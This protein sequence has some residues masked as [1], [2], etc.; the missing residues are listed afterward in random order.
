M[1]Q[2]S[3]TL[4]VVLCSLLLAPA[5]SPRAEPEPAATTRA[6]PAAAASAD[7]PADEPA[8]GEAATDTGAGE[9]DVIEI[10]TEDDDRPFNL[11]AG[12]PVAPTPASV[13]WREVTSD[14][15]AIVFEYVAGGVLA[16]I[17]DAHY[18]RDE[19]GALVRL[20][21]FELPAG[22]LV[23][24][25]PDDAW[26]VRSEPA[27][28]A[29]AVRYEVMQLD[30]DH[31][32]I[33]REVRGETSW[34]AEAQAVRKSGQAGVLLRDGSR[35]ARL[36]SLRPTSKVGPRMGKQ[37]L[38]VFE[39]RSGRL[40]TISD[41]VNGVYVQRDCEERAC[42]QENARRLPHGHAWS[43]SMQIP[44]QQHSA[45]MV[46]RVVEDA[47]EGVMLLHYERGGWKLENLTRAP[48]GLWPD[49]DGGLWMILGDA[50]WH[51]SVG[52]AWVDVALPEGAGSISA[53]MLPDQSEVWLAARVDGRGVV[54]ATPASPAGEDDG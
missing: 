26:I 11:L 20:T 52:G 38:D 42:V 14:D 37:I 43:F 10:A 5:C 3:P 12:S 17:G 23:G 16:R 49:A 45:S 53:A 21:E 30:A 13:A 22:E 8:P 32:W 46:A 7:A 34:L 47:V 2:R 35:V 41:R 44:R 15:A 31:A 48:R 39:T 24:Y 36:G 1:N 27:T 29:D 18:E 28:D 25:W 40:Y 50:L 33:A 19:S 51:R 9:A 54:F 4:Q 6:P